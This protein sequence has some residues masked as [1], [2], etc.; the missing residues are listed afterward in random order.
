MGR[1][2]RY[3]SAFTASPDVTTGSSLV[4]VRRRGIGVSLILTLPDDDDA[5]RLIFGC[6]SV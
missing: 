4:T 2:W 5:K 1:D 6:E 3:N